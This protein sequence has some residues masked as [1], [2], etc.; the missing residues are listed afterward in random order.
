MALVHEFGIIDTFS[1]ASFEDYSPEKYPCISVNDTHIQ[2][3]LR[4]LSLVKTYF[5]SLDRPEFGLAYY[6]TTIISP[7]SFAT[8]LEVVLSAK[9]INQQEDII[10]LSQL[11]LQAK[12][13]NKYMIHYGV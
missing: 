10:E 5:H 6:G 4:S 1:A 8:L 9:K 12:R 13:E 11:I 3:L 7:E 2:A